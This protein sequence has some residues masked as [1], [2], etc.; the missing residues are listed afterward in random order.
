[1]SGPSP[2]LSWRELASRDGDPYPAPWRGSRAVALAQAFEAVRAACGDVPITVLSA[3]RT[4]AHNA[5]VGGAPKSQHVQGRALDLRVPDGMTLDTFEA[6]VRALC[7]TT[8]IRG[9][10]RYPRKRSLHIDVRPTQRV[11]RWHGARAW[12]EPV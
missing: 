2:H 9:I 7:A 10:G 3:Y 11:V 8:K 6:T 1:M 5:R 12:S 4:P